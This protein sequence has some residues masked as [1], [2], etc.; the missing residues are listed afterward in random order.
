[1]WKTPPRRSDRLGN[2]SR[3]SEIEDERCAIFVRQDVRTLPPALTL[4]DNAR[5]F[6]WGLM[7]F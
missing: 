1:M 7:L 2:Q 4:V 3:E 6:R 5:T